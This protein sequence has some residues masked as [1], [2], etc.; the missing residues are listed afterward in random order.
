MSIA[1]QLDLELQR[2]AT[3]GF[4]PPHRFVL[5]APDGRLHGDL[6]SLD[7][8][9]CSLNHLE[10]EPSRPHG[11]AELKEIAEWLCRQVR[12]LLE[13]LAVI[14]TDPAG[15]HLQIRSYPPTRQPQATSYYEALVSSSGVTL[16]RYSAPPGAP[17]QPA[18]MHV[19]REI[20]ERLV[21]DLSESSQHA[22][23]GR[24]V[25]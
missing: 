13:P 5:A 3:G 12:Y 15:V 23:A 2:L 22:K 18:P 16:R 17:R 1:H 14:E 9:G 6:E 24:R 11:A 21:S 19:T 20:L 25:P 8:I 7:S 10:W 4:T